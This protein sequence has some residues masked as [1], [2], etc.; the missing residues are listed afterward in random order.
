MNEKTKEKVL[1]AAGPMG[2]GQLQSIGAFLKEAKKIKLK[3]DL[4]PK[5]VEVK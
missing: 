1:A 4:A 3:V 2:F 5:D